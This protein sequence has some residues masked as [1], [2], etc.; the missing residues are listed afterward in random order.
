[1]NATEKIQA[2]IEKLEKS[3]GVYAIYNGWLIEIDPAR[4]YADRRVP[5]TSDPLIVMLYR[6]VDAQLTILRHDLAILPKYDAAG[7]RENWE[8]AIEDAGD[9]SLAEAILA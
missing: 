4:H 5:L 6:T 1:M 8:L 9:L 2:A 3:L 7:M